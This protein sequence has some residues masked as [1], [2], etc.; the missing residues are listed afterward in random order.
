MLIKHALD[1]LRVESQLRIIQYEMN[2]RIESRATSKTPIEIIIISW[3]FSFIDLFNLQN[4][5]IGRP[6]SNTSIPKLS[7]E[8]DNKYVIIFD[9]S[10][11]WGVRLLYRTNWSALE[12]TDKNFHAEVMSA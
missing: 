9:K 10:F 8:F 6:R 2:V 1:L 5:G 11:V 12:D 4:C 7:E 3:N